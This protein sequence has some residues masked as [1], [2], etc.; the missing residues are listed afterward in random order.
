MTTTNFN[1]ELEKRSEERMTLKDMGL[2][3]NGK[4][5]F[6]WAKIYVRRA[7]DLETVTSK[8][9]E[10]Y[11]YDITAPAKERWIAASHVADTTVRGDMTQ[12][13]RD[14]AGT[15]GYRFGAKNIK[16]AMF[17]E[18][19]RQREANRQTRF[20]QAMEAEG[21]TAPARLAAKT[22]M[23]TKDWGKAYGI[24]KD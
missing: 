14:A 15:Y 2:N 6:A 12:A 21:K 22:A 4:N 10:E 20:E 18:A 8:Y 23:A 24:F 5:T 17:K 3:P 11:T 7:R 9:G 19:Y 1:T 16:L 13:E